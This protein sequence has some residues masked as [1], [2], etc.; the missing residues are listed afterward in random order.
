M[1][2]RGDIRSEWVQGHLAEAARIATL[3][4]ADPERGP[5]VAE[6]ALAAAL[7][8]VPRRRLDGR[9]ADALLAQLV[10]QSRAHDPDPAADGTPEQLAVLRT[11]PRRQRAA[12]VLRHYAELSDDRAAVFL[13]C[14]PKAVADLTSRAVRALPPEARSD[15]HGWLDAAPL[16]RP[17]AARHRRSALRRVF[18]P[19]VLRALALAT[20]VVAGVLAGVRLPEL[21]RATEPPTRT[22]DIADIREELELQEADLPFDPDDPGP[23]ASPMFPVVDGVIGGNV[24]MIAGYRDET[25]ASCLQLVVAFDFG[26][27]RCLDGAERPISAVLDVDREHGV[28]FISGKVAAGIQ[29]LQF[30]GPDVPWMDVTIGRENPSSEEPQP[31]FFGIALPDEFIAVDS[32]KDGRLGGYEVLT[33]RLTAIDA[34][35]RAVAKVPL[36]LARS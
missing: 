33:G 15:L 23:G 32:R 14:S 24:W 34:R 13:G 11:L 9:L 22:E 17:A 21:L 28:T 3:L 8:V 31:G 2:S 16:P 7:E 19:R 10:R 5:L 6:V 26:R 30:V 29:E 18:R 4:T 25:G 35:G 12:L 1:P 36:L 20:A 27:R